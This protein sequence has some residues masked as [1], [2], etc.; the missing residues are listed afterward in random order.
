MSPTYG[1]GVV[2]VD[3]ASGWTSHDVVAKVRG[4]VGV[5][6]VGHAG[7]LDPMATGLLVVGLLRATRLLGYLAATNKEYLAT[8]RLG[9]T[10]TSDDAEGEVV[11]SVDASGVSDDA[12]LAAMKEQTG[13]I[14]Q[15]PSAVSAIKVDGVRAYKKARAGETVELQPRPVTVEAFERVERRGDD[16]DVRVVCSSGTYVRAL[17]RDVGAALGVGAHLTSLRRTRVGSFSV[18]DAR[19]LDD[20]RGLAHIPLDDLVASTFPRLD[21]DE[22]TARRISQGQKIQLDIAEPTGVFG[23]DR[24][25]VALV[26]ARDDGTAKSL[27]GFIG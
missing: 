19:P 20:E 26:D 9:V 3:K 17:A 27:V 5:K 15:V 18:H 11:D 2:L 16:I 25:V 23:P 7:T 14:Q 24:H 8:M 4:I 22:D 1:D 13:E 21:V 6:K 10:T 12:L